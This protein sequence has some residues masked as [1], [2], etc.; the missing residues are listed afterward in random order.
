LKPAGRCEFGGVNVEEEDE[1]AAANLEERMDEF[2]PR[3]GA[4][5]GETDSI[6]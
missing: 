6:L 1:V 4:D 5:E 3:R 2:E